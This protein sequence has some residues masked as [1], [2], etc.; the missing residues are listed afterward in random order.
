MSHPKVYLG[1]AV[2]AKS[3]GYGVWLTTENGIS[4][5]NEVYLEPPVFAALVRYVEGLNRQ[6]YD[7]DA[8]FVAHATKA[9]DAAMGAVN[10]E[11]LS[12]D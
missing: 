5:T 6:P 10:E 12:R 9:D 3:D 4:T 2:Y 11:G 8:G 1:D 7:P